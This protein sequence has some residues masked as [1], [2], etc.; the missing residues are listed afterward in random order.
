MS[1]IKSSAVTDS[2]IKK[3]FSSSQVSEEFSETKID[4]AA[5]SVA[6]D[7]DKLVTVPEEKA[8]SV[9]EI[10]LPE[11]ETANDHKQNDDS[12]NSKDDS[13][14]EHDVIV[15]PN[16]LEHNDVTEKEESDNK[17]FL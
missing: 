6:D 15:N 8:A 13:R 9:S 14:P 3:D 5:E 17:T 12:L 16:A 1:S 4:L 11:K 2:I 10:A 7:K